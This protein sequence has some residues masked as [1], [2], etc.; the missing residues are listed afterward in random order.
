[1]C[2]RTLHYTSPLFFWINSILK[3]DMKLSSPVPDVLRRQISVWLSKQ[4][5]DED[6]VHIH[7]TQL[8]TILNSHNLSRPYFSTAPAREDKVGSIS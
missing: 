3:P 5:I 4:Q 2:N 1:M 8:L 6:A 7:I